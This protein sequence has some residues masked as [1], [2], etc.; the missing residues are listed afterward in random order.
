M[1][2]YWNA[3]K[4]SDIKS[5]SNGCSGKYSDA[6]VHEY[7]SIEMIDGS[8]HTFNYVSYEG[9]HEGKKARLEIKKLFNEYN[10]IPETYILENVAHAIINGQTVNFGYSVIDNL[11]EYVLFTNKEIEQ[12]RKE[13]KIKDEGWR[14]LCFIEMLNIK[15][16]KVI[17]AIPQRY[18][19]QLEYMGYDISK[20]E[21]ELIE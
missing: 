1:W 7:F 2:G 3:V 4:I 18:L 10:N 8:R 15:D 17:G 14:H 20:L 16:G 5:V 6:K 9:K 12:L 19:E 13:F 11:G 21:Y